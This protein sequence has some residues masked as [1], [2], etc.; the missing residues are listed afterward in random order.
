M[1]INGLIDGKIGHWMENEI[2]DVWKEMGNGC[3]NR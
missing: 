3:G 1:I 2:K